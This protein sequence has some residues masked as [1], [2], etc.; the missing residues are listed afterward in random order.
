M[1]EEN[2][3]FEA[4]K[5]LPQPIPL[6]VGEDVIM[7]VAAKISGGGGLTGVDGVDLKG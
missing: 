6:V 1:D 4:Y 7:K 2:R 5:S 3:T